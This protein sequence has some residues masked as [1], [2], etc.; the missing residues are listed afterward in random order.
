MLVHDRHVVDSRDYNRPFLRPVRDSLFIGNSKVSPSELGQPSS[1][2][3]QASSQPIV[4]R[5]PTGVTAFAILS[6][7]FAIMGLLSGLFSLTLMVTGNSMSTTANPVNELLANNVAYRYFYVAMLI[8]GTFFSALLFVAGLKL[9][10][11]SKLGR[12]LAIT[13]AFYA[14]LATFVSTA[15]NGFL[16]F[17]PMIQQ[18]DQQSDE[19]QVIIVVTL[20]VAVFSFCFSLVFPVALLIYFLRRSAKQMFLDW[21][22]PSTG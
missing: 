6:I 7:L 11:M 4:S 22:Q 14:I 8:A 12:S 13:Y 16:L 15:V 5:R 21:D 18:L 10:K 20:L 2:R 9:L 3:P 17:I 19:Q 1:L